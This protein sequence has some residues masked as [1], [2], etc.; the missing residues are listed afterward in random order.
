MSSG[1]DIPMSRAALV[2]VRRRFSMTSV[3][4]MTAFAVAR[5][6]SGSGRPRSAKTCPE[7]ITPIDVFL[8]Q[9][10]LAVI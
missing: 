4:S 10:C 9:A 1:R 7:P 6:A 5:C 3:I 8:V 2:W